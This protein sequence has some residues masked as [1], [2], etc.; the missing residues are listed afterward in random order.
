[1]DYFCLWLHRRRFINQA[2]LPVFVDSASFNNKQGHISSTKYSSNNDLNHNMLN[3]ASS[4]ILMLFVI[5][6]SM[7][8]ARAI[9]WT[10]DN[11]A[12][13]CDFVGNDLSN[14]QI[15][16]EDCG[17][18]CVQ[19]QDC[20]H[21]T[22]TQWNDGTCWLKKGSVSKNNAVSTDDK[23]MVCGIIDNQGPPTTP[24]SSGTTTR[25]WDCCKPSC[26]WSGK[27][28]GSNSYVKSCRKDGSSVFDHS[29]A[30]S[31]CE[32]GEAFPCNN[33]KPWAINDQ[34]AYGFAAAS[35]PGLNERD[36]CCA[37]YKLD[38]TSGPVSG[39][40]M[41][42]QVTNSGDDLK[43]HQFDLQIPGGGV[44]KFNGCTTQWNA[45]GNG[46]GE[47]YGGVS[48][49]DA[50]FGLP[51][52]IRAGCFFR[53]DWFKGADNPTMTYSRVKCPAELVNI[54]GCSRS[55]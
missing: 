1:M 20:T 47:R 4:W 34:L 26:S 18:K 51:E 9:Q 53:F 45:P 31:G 5:I 15:R 7:S 43:P 28:S 23:N 49:R 46:W 13:G 55:D 22:W 19:T 52:A 17:L 6:N 29:N 14:V 16:G 38:F 10:E 32:G 33:Q 41:I 50:C 27:V 25:Y 48:S 2:Y 40:T 54:S 42:V 39:K 3:T 30:V 37:C 8:S 36:R 11:W 44:G 12:F 35:I 24:G 21:F